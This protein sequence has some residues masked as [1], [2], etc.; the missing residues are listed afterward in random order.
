MSAVIDH[1]RKVPLFRGMSTSALETVADRASE[2]TFEDGETLTR[3]GEPGDTFYIVTD[4]RLHVSKGGTLVRDLGPG[5]FLG[6]I[7]LVDGGP[8]T[9]TVTADGPVEALVIRRADF[10]EMVEWDSAVRL[11]ILT[12]LTERIR[13]TDPGDILDEPRGLRGL[14]EPRPRGRRVE[15]GSRAAH[16]RPAERGRRRRR[17]LQVEVLEHVDQPLARPCVA[18][19]DP[20]RHDGLEPRQ[21]TLVRDLVV[22]VRRVLHDPVDGQRDHGVLGD[23]ADLLEGGV[24]AVA[25]VLEDLEADEQVEASS[26]IGHGVHRASWM[27]TLAGTSRSGSSR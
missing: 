10:L 16:R 18:D 2:T 13:K 4:G 24:L 14:D 23:P 9:A 15:R 25:Q 20:R 22:G 3:E 5:D 27:M 12:A 1:M 19:L 6:E 8:R 7:A 17:D 21:G 11:G 26:S